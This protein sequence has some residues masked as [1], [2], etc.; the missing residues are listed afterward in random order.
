MKTGA[1]V[2]RPAHQQGHTII[3]TLVVCLVLG[4]VLLGI[5]KLAN[6]EGQMNGRSQN[7]NAVMPLVEAG[8]EEALT[9]LKHS[10]SNRASDGWSFDAAKNHFTRTRTFADGFYQVGISTNYDPVITSHAGIRAPG[11]SQYSI[12][13]TV[14]VRAT[15]QPLIN[16]GMEGV[17]SVELS[18][19]KLRL[20]SYDSRDPKHSLPNGKYDPAEAKDGGDVVSYGGTASLNVGNADIN[21]RI[22]TGP[23][24]T[25]TIGPNGSVG[26]FSWNQKGVE[27]GWYEELPATEYPPITPP[28]GGVTPPKGFG[29]TKDYQYVLGAALYEVSAVAGSI[30]VNGDATLVVKDS[31]SLSGKDVIQIQPG[32]S[33]KL[34][35]RAASASLSGQAVANPAT[36]SLKLLYFGLPSNTVITMSGNSAFN[37][38][39]Y[40]PDAFIQLSGGGND[41]V[42]FSGA[43]LGKEIK[44][45]GHYNFHYDEAT[46]RLGSRGIVAA[47]WDE[48]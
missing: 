22:K 30:L 37:G 33:L 14:R 27:P 1:I 36:D 4:V 3:V 40:A 6:T 44:L 46:R 42:D 45:K 5:I 48:L 15:N 28:I 31:F 11:Q 25:Y 41:A 9:H 38:V 10:P 16:A 29:P 19:G 23:D 7:W 35:V 39:I 24:A 47:S 18:G 26:S 17:A 21:G 8:I 32:A 2:P 43:I 34:Y 12:F 13:R 20:D